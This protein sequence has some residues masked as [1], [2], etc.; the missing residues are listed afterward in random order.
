MLITEVIPKSQIKPITK[1]LLDIEGYKCTLNFDPGEMNLGASGIRGVA[2]YTK[3]DLKA[4]EVDLTTEDFCD[5]VWI[6][7]PLEKGNTVLC[8]CVYRSPSDANSRACMES[9]K[10]VTKLIRTAYHRNRNLIVAGDFNYKEIDWVNEYAPPSQE[11]LLLFIETLQNCYLFQHVTEPTRYRENQNANLLDLIL[12]SEEGM[13]EDVSY[14]TPLGES[15]HAILMFNVIHTPVKSEIT[16]KLNIYKTDYEELRKEMSKHKWQEMLISDFEKDYD[17]FS[18]ILNS[19]LVKYSPLT[20]PP[21]KKNHPYINNMAIRLKNAK[22]RAW[23]RYKL[24]RTKHDREAYTRCKNN[25]RELTRNLRKD[26]E[27]NL[28]C[29]LKGK[30]KLFWK[31]AKSRL[32]T[33]QSV[34]TLTKPEGTKAITA[35][36]KAKTLNQFFTSVFTLEDMH[37]IPS[38]TMIEV[39][40]VLSTIEITPDI[41]WKKLNS[42][43]P[44]K[45]PGND[46]WHPHFLKEL[47]D[48]ICAP[49]SILFNK[50][51]KEG[52]HKTWRNAVIT[53]IYKKGLKSDPGNYRPVSLTSV[54]SKVMESIIRDAIVVHLMENNLLSDEQHGF[55]P[56]R[57]CITQLLL[58]LEDW[59]T[60]MEKGNAFDLIYTDFSKAFDSVAHLRLLVKLENVGIGGDVLKWITS[61]LTERKQ[62]VSV[63][64][65]KSEWSKVIS[66]I[67]QGSVLGPILFVIFINDMPE[68]VKYNI[69]KLFADDCKLYGCVNSTEENKVQFDL[70]SLENW[71][72]KWQLPFNATKCKVMHFGHNNPS[73]SYYLNDHMLEKTNNEKDLGVFIDSSLKFHVHT[74]AALKKANQVLGI[75][76]KSYT[77]RDATTIST[78]YKAMVRPHLEYGNVIWGPFYQGDV[79]MLESLQRRATKLVIRLKDRPYE[80]RL[81][82]LRLP[83]LVYRRKRGNMIQM[84]KIMNGIVRMNKNDIFTPCTTPYTRGHSQKVFKSHAIKQPRIN[85]FSKRVVNDWNDLPSDVITAPSVIEFKIRLDKYWE[86]IH[87]VF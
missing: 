14:H 44:N 42:L 56:G 48:T 30:P 45:S 75:I 58:C 17:T 40:E 6:E 43:N 34:P 50:S 20:T 26:F 10:K 9:T 71:S 52:A 73:H 35:K 3:N 63:E 18:N 46:K 39:K 27:N 65:T 23:K 22:G 8:G 79:N 54:I 29:K 59:S 37:N 86:K 38:T 7:I 74:A 16:P 49:L 64:G 70:T 41:V 4:I 80:E 47:A 67:P 62:C 25:L 61:F 24:T 15:D 13:V 31:Y 55:V 36:D 53:A 1:A 32:K 19:L 72:K 2:I 69:C 76:K 33:R 83:S 60:F 5:H 51:L 78:L 77:T 66:G 87:Y 81:R 11:H 57:D 85:A 12:S 82:E 84:Y 28:A 68:E 21:K